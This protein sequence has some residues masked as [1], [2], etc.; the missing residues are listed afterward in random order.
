MLGQLGEVLETMEGTNVTILIDGKPFP[1]HKIILATRSPV[2]K[3]DLYGVIHV[4]CDV[5][6]SFC[7]PELSLP[8]FYSNTH[9]CH[10]LH[11]AQRSASSSAAGACPG[12]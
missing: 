5:A 4:S 9:R 7:D 2:F 8:R 12:P 11:H 10:V 6:I 1:V 3:T